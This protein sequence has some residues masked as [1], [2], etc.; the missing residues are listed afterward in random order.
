MQ[1]S[2]DHVSVVHA[3]ATVPVNLPTT[4]QFESTYGYG[5]WV[6]P[7]TGRKQMAV[8]PW[9]AT[10]S[11][12]CDDDVVVH[13]MSSTA[14]DSLYNDF[15]ANL[16]NGSTIGFV[17]W[18]AHQWLDVGQPGVPNFKRFS[19]Q[20]PYEFL[21]A[22][23]AIAKSDFY[24][25]SQIQFLASYFDPEWAGKGGIVDEQAF[26]DEW[27]PGQVRVYHG[28]WRSYMNR[29]VAW[30]RERKLLFVQG[31][32]VGA[33]S[34][35]AVSGGSGVSRSRMAARFKDFLESELRMAI[36]CVVPPQE[37]LE[38]HAQLPRGTYEWL[39]RRRFQPTENA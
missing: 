23:K 21:S 29:L 9:I 28:A 32:V 39:E 19:W 37:L 24:S 35:I 15:T 14:S 18:T 34:E 13:E 5:R 36:Y 12:C 10:V 7:W 25:D 1:H 4:W 6:S 2:C 20:Q 22:F 26:F 27:V 8:V 16:P 31:V 3:M 30:L 33:T 38:F 11:V 17:A